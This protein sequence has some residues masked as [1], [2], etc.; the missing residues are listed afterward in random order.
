MRKLRYREIKYL[1]ARYSSGKQR[2]GVQIQSSDFGGPAVLHQAM[3]RHCLGHSQCIDDGHGLCNAERR[4]TLANRLPVGGEP[5]R[6][7]LPLLDPGLPPSFSIA[8][9]ITGGEKHA[10]TKFFPASAGQPWGG[11]GGRLLGQDTRKFPTL[12]T[13][14]SRQGI[15]KT[16][17]E[18]GGAM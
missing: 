10:L 18:R 2:V 6:P 13:T 3:R 11:I 16:D 9:Q 4:Q 12:H 14:P 5:T 17:R 7:H 1:A 8:P 15:K